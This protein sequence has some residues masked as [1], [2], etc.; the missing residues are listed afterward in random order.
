MTLKLHCLPFYYRTA[1][2][3]V[4]LCAIYERTLNIINTLQSPLHVI[5]G[6]IWHAEKTG[7]DVALTVAQAYREHLST[8]ADHLKYIGRKHYD[9]YYEVPS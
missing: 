4:E 3:I 8:R 2:E 9:V 6:H 1:E 7:G 5:D